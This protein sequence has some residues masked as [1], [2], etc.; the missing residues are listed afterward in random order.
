M[1]TER[2]NVFQNSTKDR[3]TH[4]NISAAV[5]RC[6]D[7]NF[8]VDGLLYVYSKNSKLKNFNTVK[9]CIDW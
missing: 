2:K 9:K 5:K 8:N 4:C 1:L 6:R 3:I 7:D